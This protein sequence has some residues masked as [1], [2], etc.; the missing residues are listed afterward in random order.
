MLTWY[1]CND[2]FTKCF[3][4]SFLRRTKTWYGL[5]TF[6]SYK[7]KIKNSSNQIKCCLWMVQSWCLF[8]AEIN[9]FHFKSRSYK[10][11]LNITL[12]KWRRD[13]KSDYGSI[14]YILGNIVKSWIT[15]LKLGK[16]FYIENILMFKLRPNKMISCHYWNFE[17]SV[18]IG[19]GQAFG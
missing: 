2:I 14:T 13:K 9:I 5:T 1:N 7:C 3:A 17:K 6:H 11:L 12:K 19:L 10:T 18:F 16:H 4:T 8:M 15:L